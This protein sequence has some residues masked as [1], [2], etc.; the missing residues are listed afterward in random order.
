MGKE[1]TR[2]AG[3]GETGSLYCT[4]EFKDGHGRLRTWHDQFKA[5]RARSIP[6]GF[7]AVATGCSSQETRQGSGMYSCMTSRLRPSL[8]GTKDSV[9][10]T[11]K[12][13]E[14]DGQHLEGPEWL[15]GQA[16]SPTEP[17]N[18]QKP[19]SN[20]QGSCLKEDDN[21]HVLLLL[22]FITSWPKTG[23]LPAPGM[24]KIKELSEI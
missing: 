4:E 1:E 7:P 13:W 6:E 2:W 17:S 19:V 11:M 22:P 20:S 10:R 21:S 24:Q 16:L 12:A 15:R 3:W 23:P 8:W 18:W 14:L 5:Q 9:W